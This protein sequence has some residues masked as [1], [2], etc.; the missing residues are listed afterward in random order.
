MSLIERRFV[1]GAPSVFGAQMTRRGFIRVAGAATLAG[2]AALTTTGCR[3]KEG[4]AFFRGEREIVDDAGRKVVIP[5]PDKLQRIYYTSALAQVWVFTLD[6]SKQGG[7]SFRFT[8]EELRYLPEGTDKL[9]YMGSLSGGGELDREQL[10]AQDIQLIFSISGI[11][12]TASDISTAN[13]LQKS[14]GI[15]VV[16]VDGSFENVANAYRF[17]GDIMG[18]GDRAEEIAS[19][20]EGIYKDVTGALSGVRDEDRVSLYYAEGPFGLATEPDV[21]QHALTFEVAR[22]RNVAAVEAVSG[23]GMSSVSLESVIAWDPE[24]IV[25]W[26]DVIRGGADEIIRTDPAWATIR[27]VREGRVYTMPNAPFAWCD[28]PPGVNRFLGIQ[29]VAN[30][31]YPDLYPV[32]MLEETKEFY[33][34]LYWVDIGDDDA[35]A[36]LGNSY[37]PYRKA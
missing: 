13:D 22:A 30:M 28:R 15:P 14:T 12:L 11:A 20:L 4:D 9:M 27:A 16:C 17:V 19:Y 1:G 37:P 32:D 5:V 31:L 3:S 8:P 18:A 24:V 29:W 36:L 2:A 34:R 7:V 10:L 26:D 33:R 25:A 35:R 21:S 6:P 23:I